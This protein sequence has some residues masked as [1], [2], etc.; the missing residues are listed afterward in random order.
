M[1]YSEARGNVEPISTTKP[2]SLDYK[3]HSL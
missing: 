1:A 2:C 3:S